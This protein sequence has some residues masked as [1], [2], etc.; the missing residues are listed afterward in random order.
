LFGSFDGDSPLGHRPEP[1]AARKA[2]EQHQREDGG[3]T[4]RDSY[5]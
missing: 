4:R 5:A 1:A 3:G 2:E